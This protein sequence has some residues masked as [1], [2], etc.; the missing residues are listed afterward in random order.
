MNRI[1]QGRV[2]RV[3]TL[4]KGSA[5]QLLND[6]PKVLWQH[7]ELFQDAVNYYTLALATMAE[8]LNADSAKGKAALAW[9]EQVRDSWLHARRKAIGFPGPHIRLAKW[10]DVNPAETDPTKAFEESSA[11]LLKSSPATPE[12]RA[13]A[14]LQML[15][16]VDQ[17]DLNQFCVS[18]LPWLCTP[19]GKLDA[20][21]KNVVQQQEARML[22]IIGEIHNASAQDIEA[23]AE[24][25]E[26]GCFVTQMPKETMTG[27]EA[28]TEAERLFKA[29]ASKAKGLIAVA[30]RFANRLNQLGDKLALPCLGRKPKGVYPL[31]VVFRLLPM[32][33]TW[34]AFKSATE[35]L[36]KKA[37]KTKDSP[38]ELAND[39]IAE[40]RTT[41]D[42]PVFDYFSNRT[43]FRESD[44]DDRAVWFDF[45]LAAFI[46]A[47]KA[48]H[49]FFRDS[50][51]RETAANL[52]RRK[53]LAMEG[54]GGDLD[55]DHGEEEE[56][57]GAFGFEGDERIGLLRK[58]VKD[59]LGFLAETENHG[60]EPGRIEYTI[61]ER[62]VRGFEE[63]KEKWQKLAVSGRATGES[64]LDVLK[65]QQAK[66]RDD[67]GS[68]TLYRTLA[69]PE[70]Q[71]IWRNAGTEKWHATDPL[72]AWRDYK[73][74]CFE[75]QD[76]ERPIRFT[77]AHP[78]HSPR[79]FIIP[80]QGRFG[81][82]HQA[83]C[84][85]FTCGI[86]VDTQRGREVT[87]VRISYSAPRLRRDELRHDGQE[88]LE[89]VPWIQ[90]MMKALG[91]PEADQQ[92]FANCRVTLQ[93]KTPA[94]IQLTFPVEVNSDKLIAG[95]A[96]ADRWNRQF[97]VHPD[98][99]KFYNATLRWPHEKQP[100]KAPVP[101]HEQ[102]ESFSCLA[103]DLGQR[104]A[105]AFARLLARSRGDFD[106]RP[107]R[108]IGSTGD[109]LWRATLERKGLFRLPGEDSLV[110]REASRLDK[111]N[112]NDSGSQFD[113]RQELWGERGRSA[114]PW[115][116]DDTAELMQ[117]LEVP[118]N[119]PAFTL[120]PEDWRSSLSF[121]EQNDKLLVGMRRY[122]SRI[123]RL[124]RWCWFVRGDE[125][126]QKSA[127]DEISDCDDPR[128]I[129]TEQRARASKRDPRL[130]EELEFQLRE[131]LKLAP[132]L[133]V[134][135]ANRILP[136]RGRSWRWD[137]DPAA[138][139]DVVLYQ[140][141]QRGASLDSKDRPIW[142]RGQRG[143]SFERI[144][145]VEE[146][147]K[148]FQSL[149]QT[150]R[151]KV[152]GKPPSRRDETVPDPCPDLLDK[153]DHLKEQ[154]VNQTAHM[155][156]AEGLGLRLA[157]PPTDKK[158]LRRAND[159]HG[160]YEKIS[161]KDGQWIGPVDFI[162]IEDLSRY[163]AS[164]GRAPRE[165]SRLMKWCHRS[166]RD[167]LKELC[168]PFGIPVIETPAAWSSRFCARSG[169]A[170]FRAVEI[171]P[172]FDQEPP[173]RWLKDRKD[174]DKLTQE[175]ELVQQLIRQ[176]AEANVGR[177][178]HKRKFRTLLAP[179]A[180]GPIFV[181]IKDLVP[182]ADMKPAIV[183]ADINAAIN[184]GLRTIADPRLWS[185]FPRLRTQ[186]ERQG[187]AL[188]AREK[189]RFGERHSP[190]LS[191]TK[192]EKLGNNEARNS[193]FFADHARCVDTREWGDA[194][195][196]DG[197]RLV[198]GKALWFT[199]KEH[200]WRRIGEINER[201]LLAW[202]SKEDDVPM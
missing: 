199:V 30:D 167:K 33:E 155:I 35:S 70:F 154:R 85:A 11:A 56:D 87:S 162:V 13:K 183:Q 50:L 138:T 2:A 96:K 97:N 152:G 141:G 144:E 100:S 99:D 143:L 175:A 67:F 25:L 83:G 192:P 122:Q 106:K 53:K 95:I 186:C 24:H 102:I 147:R 198:S 80:K 45:D 126:Q 46:E 188:A 142:L 181:P 3:E 137:E 65:E 94:N 76:K 93:P 82:D 177:D 26:L 182:G 145:Q 163:R 36:R 120:L 48:P 63:I 196:P 37:E 64:L 107:S 146:L 51:E 1:Y 164:Q 131:R 174:G 28:R 27:V 135:I 98:G 176:L 47:I 171:A 113:F 123:S 68:A 197:T 128:L 114:R 190:E 191:V 187:G 41:A 130:R 71:P 17:L 58:L 88:D 77:P 195:L 12:A 108:A 79:Y 84:L 16:E 202:K 29:A 59:T 4:G 153:L 18:R 150:L 160:V 75:L 62:T 118:P 55:D 20:T 54:K 172:G 132:A 178:G 101:W 14:L 173:W 134:R 92:D 86:I 194:T 104:D 168:Q 52:L 32:P 129:T 124:H 169:A 109:G 74:L 158:A 15:E 89:S 116:A 193:N 110:W 72:K 121:P 165:N 157:P 103:T 149:N 125:K 61:Q 170:G 156:L 139:G 5:D 40:V 10:L 201:R 78:E 31:A 39:F 159:Q 184:L 21:P 8:G 180:S 148:R 185:I 161:G 81:C 22:A 189:R 69:Q 7:H 140:L 119:D 200:Q 60:D 9:R 42:E 38:V 57:A 49:R 19:H 111:I 34:E 43:L 105:G 115:E 117:A 136:L 23:V 44:N 6:W 133:L 90:P 91:L 151:R 66:H 73:E 179:L 166:V 112:P 127:W